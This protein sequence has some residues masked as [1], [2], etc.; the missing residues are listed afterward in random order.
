MTSSQLLEDAPTFILSLAYIVNMKALHVSTVLAMLALAPPGAVESAP[1]WMRNLMESA[2]DSSMTI[3]QI[4]YDDL[5]LDVGNHNQNGAVFERWLV[6]SGG[7]DSDSAS[8]PN[9]EILAY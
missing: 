2:D 8:Q 1:N 9:G 4:L 6:Q 5:F 7:T 3:D